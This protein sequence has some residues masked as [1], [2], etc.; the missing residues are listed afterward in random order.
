MGVWEFSIRCQYEYP[1]LAVSRELPGIPL[2]VWFLWDR[3]IVQIPTS[4]PRTLSR[5][6]REI[7]DA[8]GLIDEWMD[9]PVGRVVLAR[10]R[11]EGASGIGKLLAEAR[12]WAAPPISYVNGWAHLRIMAFE[13]GAVRDLFRLLEGR[14]TAVL[15]SKSELPLSVLPSSIWI[16]TL[17]GNMT[18]RQINAL[19]EA[20]RS[21]YYSIPR[22]VGTREI[23]ERLGAKRT[24]YGEHLRKAESRLIESVMPYVQIYSRSVSKKRR[25][26][27]AT[28]PGEARSL[29]AP[30][31]P[32]LA[33]PPL[34][35]PR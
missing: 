10:L 5:V 27:P 32:P 7:T 12:C 16:H 15:V 9:T 17:F 35:G 30:H 28:A 21:G 14:G 34:T 2:N 26:P 29:P 20:Y 18:E 6:A 23:A 24:T 19:D 13:E 1:L 11:F 25:R 3:A 31:A 4:D 8:G 22:R 33:E